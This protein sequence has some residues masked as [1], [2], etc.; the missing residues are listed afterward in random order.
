[1]KFYDDLDV[2]GNAINNV[3]TP[4]AGTDVANKTYVDTAAGGAGA[5]AQTIGDGVAVSYTVTHNLNTM[6]V[7]VDVYDA[8]T[9]A[10][11]YPDVTRAT[12]NTVT[13]AFEIAPTTGQYRTLV[14]K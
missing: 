11:V 6:D 9:G 13:V 10:T 1:V 12:L 5:V 2:L 3:K 7:S 4:V 14:R 8:G